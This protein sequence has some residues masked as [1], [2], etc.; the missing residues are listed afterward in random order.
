M[1]QNQNIRI[2]DKKNS[3]K[4]LLPQGSYSYNCWAGAV[5]CDIKYHQY[6]V[7]ILA[8]VR[9]CGVWTIWQGPYWNRI[10]HKTIWILEQSLVL[11]RWPFHPQDEKLIVV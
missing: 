8:C 10:C 11:H 7:Q 9:S 6:I 5:H 1:N 3:L 4:K 2:F